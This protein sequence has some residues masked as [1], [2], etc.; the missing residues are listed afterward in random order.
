M[1]KPYLFILF[2]VL[3]PGI[4]LCQQTDP[5]KEELK[6]KYENSDMHQETEKKL[7]SA[8]IYPDSIVLAPLHFVD[9]YVKL[10]TAA[11]DFESLSVDVDVQTEIPGDYNLYI[12]TADATINKIPFYCGIQTHAGGKPINGGKDEGI[13]SGGIFS[14]WME[15]N[16]AALK[17]NGYYTSSETEGD[18][19]SIRM[20]RQLILQSK[21][22]R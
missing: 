8:N 4:A 17:T 21:N 7:R 11:F 18:F 20:Q 13:G 6:K 12:C 15:R 14:R 5:T 22:L 1:K 10:N 2:I 3:I 16:K 9:T 19:I